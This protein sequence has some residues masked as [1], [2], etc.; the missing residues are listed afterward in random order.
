[1]K[2]RKPFLYHKPCTFLDVC[3]PYPQQKK[4]NSC[5]FLCKLEMDDWSYQL[6]RKPQ[7][8]WMILLME[9]IL[10]Q[11]RLVVHSIIYRVLYI[12]G[13]CL[14]FLNHQQYTPKN[15]HLPM[16]SD[17]FLSELLSSLSATFCLH[18]AANL[19]RPVTVVCQ[20]TQVQVKNTTYKP[21][22]CWQ[23]FGRLCGENIS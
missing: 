21:S 18:T 6:W 20:W 11:L 10:H 9:E 7:I 2:T 15:H 16:V 5:V 4:N 17:G 13:G 19:E 23:E 22:E 1:M 3:T 12:P 8:D 14:G